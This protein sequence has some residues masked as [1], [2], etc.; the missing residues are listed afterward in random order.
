MQIL[1]NAELARMRILM[2]MQFSSLVVVE[3]LRSV[4]FRVAYC[5][6]FDTNVVSRLEFLFER[7]LERSSEF[8]SS[9]LGSSSTVGRLLMGDLLHYEN[10]ENACTSIH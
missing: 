4:F 5:A 6:S 9:V 10:S 7:L 1:H 2:K 3:I 8:V